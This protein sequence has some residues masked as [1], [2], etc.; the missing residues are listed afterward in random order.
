MP[1]IAFATSSSQIDL[2]GKWT[3]RLGNDSIEHII[4]LPGTTDDACIGIPD[5]L[6]P[7]L[8]KPQLLHLTRKNRF[9][10]NASYTR[11]ITV[12]EDMAR[13]PLRI[14]LERVMWKSCLEIDGNLLGECRESLT[15]P[16]EYVLKEG[17]TAGKHTVTLHIDNSKQYEISTN[18]LAHAYTDDTQIMWNGVLGS[19]VVEVIPDVDIRSIQ[20]Y[21]DVASSQLLVKVGIDNSRSKCL[22]S[23]LRWEIKGFAGGESIIGKRCVRLSPGSNNLEF[24]ID[25]PFLTASRWSEF[26]PE[27]L[28]LSLQ[29]D[30]FPEIRQVDFGMREVKAED[31]SIKINGDPVFLRGTLECCIFPLT[32]TPPTDEEGWEKV[33][34][35]AKEW[36]LNHLRF[37]SWCPPDAAFRVAD[38]MGFYLQ[39]ECPLWSVDILPG[40]EG[41]NGDVKHFIQSEYDAI[42]SNY[43][44]HPS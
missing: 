36:G 4:A 10:G 22:D 5:T 29:L 8:R 3:V 24:K 20:V 31:N 16:H 28:T 11:D 13:K 43:G 41:E 39:V 35:A 37:H 17:L 23:S 12:S 42:V 14:K 9:V 1:S 7:M 30:R 19:M 27:V 34:T 15:T 6:S 32:G 40:E 33:F 2:A 38:R 18:N 44:N 26:N 25:D 21:P